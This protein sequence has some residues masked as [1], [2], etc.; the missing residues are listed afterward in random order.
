M[1][2]NKIYLKFLQKVNKNFTNDNISVDKGR[3]IFIFNE[4]TNKF[5]EWCLEKRN[6]DDIRDIQKLLVNDL[7][8]NLKST[9]I[10]SESFSLPDNYF[11]FSSIQV[12]ANSGNCKNQK[13]DT[14][15]IKSENKEEVL[16]DEFNKPN[17]KY[18]E[19][20]YIIN[21]D[22]VTLFTDNFNISKVFLTYYRYPIQVDIE[23]YI[24]MDGSMSTNIDS[25]FDEKIV[26]RIISI[27]A[28]EFNI[29]DDN[30]NRFPVDKD[31][32]NSRT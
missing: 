3:F 21:N 10:N 17:F 19:T 8:I 16:N 7:K 22:S 25:E 31:R 2:I 14:F 24:R 4:A 1:D 11:S 13:L 23:G 30:M 15:E 18:R 28:K 26:D 27:A 5:I 6:E 29:N 12:F 20:C 9:N 32:I